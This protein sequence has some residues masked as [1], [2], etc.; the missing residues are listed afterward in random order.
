MQLSADYFMAVSEEINL[1]VLHQRIVNTYMREQ[2]GKRMCVKETYLAD[3]GLTIATMLKFP[4]RGVGLLYV[5]PEVDET[6]SNFLHGGFLMDL[7][8]VAL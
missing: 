6:C 5:A 4:P 8:A 3:I 1:Q 7:E 2:F